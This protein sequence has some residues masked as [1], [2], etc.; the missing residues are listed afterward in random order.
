[1]TKILTLLTAMLFLSLAS[2]QTATAQCYEL[3]TTVGQLSPLLKNNIAFCPTPAQATNVCDCPAGFVAVGY[4]GIEGNSYGPMVLSQFSLRCKQ[5]N[6]DGT[7][8]AAVTVT[9]SNGL[10]TGNSADG[11]VDAAANQGMVGDELR[12][13]C[14]VD[15]LFGYSKP[16]VDIAAGLPNTTSNV[17][18]AIGGTGGS[19]QPVMYVPNGNVIVGMQTYIDPGN[20]ISAGVA[21]RY[22]PITACPVLVC[23][24]NSISLSNISACNNNGTSANTADDTFTADV[25]V[26]YSNPAATGTLNLSGDGTAAIAVGSIAA[27][28]HTFAGV[29]MSADGGVISLTASFSGDSVCT[30]TNASAGTAPNPCSFA[31]PVCSVNSIAVSNIS[32]CNDNGTPANVTDDTYTANVTVTFTNPPPSGTLVLSGNATAAVPVGSLGAGTYTFTGVTMSANGLP[33]NISAFFSA[34]PTCVLTNSNAGSAPASCSPNAPTIPTMSE[35]GLIIFALVMFTLAAVFGTQRQQAL[36]L[37][38]ATGNVSMSNRKKLPFNKS[39]YFKALPWVYLGFV[40]I[41]TTALAFGYELTSADLPGAAISGL[42]I[43]YLVQ[44]VMQPA[45]SKE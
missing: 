42:I 5:L 29:V 26:T 30:F 22:A 32:A 38:T 21:W 14:A 27:T 33:I 11:P 15:A 9:C 4:Q 37:G 3:G 2:F 24:V 35:W 40:V 34:N 43:A 20:N 7:L 44:F 12:I 23:S 8:G 41:F 28:S 1:M 17:M 6:S 19:P 36:A 31:P 39:L 16:I 45:D 18:T 13:G 10:A 25:T